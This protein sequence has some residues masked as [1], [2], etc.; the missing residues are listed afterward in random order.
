MMYFMN[1]NKQPHLIDTIV[2]FG[3]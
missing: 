3:T 2:L 1:L